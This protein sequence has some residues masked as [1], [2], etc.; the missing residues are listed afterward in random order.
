MPSAKTEDIY[1]SII[2]KNNV[3]GQMAGTLPKP[4]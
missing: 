4:T 2:K 1:E 3:Y